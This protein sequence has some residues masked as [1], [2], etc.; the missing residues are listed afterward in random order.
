MPFL[1]FETHGH[2]RE[3]TAAVRARRDRREWAEPSP[4]VEII[5]GYLNNADGPLH[6][7][8][9][10]DQFYYHMVKSTDR[11]DMDQ[12]MFKSAKVFTGAPFSDTQSVATRTSPD[13]EDLPIV[14]VDQIWLWIIDDGIIPNLSLYCL[15]LTSGCRRHGHHLLSELL[16]A[17]FKVQLLFAGIRPHQGEKP[18]KD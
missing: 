15:L 2:R 6:C 18:A 8:R 7:R 3:I 11:R 5:D 1:S 4:E 10:L 14:M 9:T 17:E 12:V 16:E 13:L